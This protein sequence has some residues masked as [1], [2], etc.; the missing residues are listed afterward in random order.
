M[1]N[2][3]ICTN[4]MNDFI[5]CLQ[6]SLRKEPHGGFAFCESLRVCSWWFNLSLN[7]P[8]LMVTTASVETKPP[9]RIQILF[10]HPLPIAFIVFGSFKLPLENHK[11]PQRSVCIT[12]V[13]LQCWHALWICNGQYGSEMALNDN[14]LEPYFHFAVHTHILYMCMCVCVRVWMCA[15]TL[16][17]TSP[18]SCSGFP[19]S[20]FQCGLVYWLIRS[21]GPLYQYGLTLTP[22]WI[23]NYTHYKVCDKIT[24]PFLIFNG[25]TVE[26]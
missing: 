3:L 25:T 13:K 4:F 10:E 15:H 5:Q 9:A 14:L 11:D 2:D 1:K 16:G 20:V 24:D 21:R 7:L 8:I 18:K 6:A 17:P 26:V 23:S 19:F 22:A 12:F